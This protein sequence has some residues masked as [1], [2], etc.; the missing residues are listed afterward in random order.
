MKGD[1]RA[2]ELCVSRIRSEL[3]S[4]SPRSCS[5]RQY[6]FSTPQR[7]T[8]LWRK[9]ARKLLEVLQLLANV[10]FALLVQQHRDQRLCA[11]RIL[12]RLRGE[13]ELVCRLV[14]VRPVLG[15]VG[16][17]LAR[18]VL[19]EE[20]D[21]VDV[22]ERPHLAGVERCELLKLHILDPELLDEVCEDSLHDVSLLDQPPDSAH[23]ASDS[24]VFQPPDMLATVDVVVVAATVWHLYLTA[25]RP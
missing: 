9:V 12:D 1:D 22:S 13:E 3:D 24:I 18:G 11:A 20:D 15:H 4:V 7:A 2:N 16:R 21:A 8:H 14:V 6:R 5:A 19:E 23:T 17:L 10:D 25:D